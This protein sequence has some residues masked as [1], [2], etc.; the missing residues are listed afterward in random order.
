MAVDTEAKRW[1]ML[2][3]AN[4]PVRSHVFNPDTNGLVSI[5]K[6]TKKGLFLSILALLLACYF[7]SVEKHI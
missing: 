6:I 3:F 5:E 1:S 4:G 7:C 2:A